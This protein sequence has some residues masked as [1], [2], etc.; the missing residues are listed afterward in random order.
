MPRISWTTLNSLEELEE[1]QWQQTLAESRSMPL[2]S[3]P[4][5]AEAAQVAHNRFDEWVQHK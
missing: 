1:A 5:A 2:M 3:Q 4:E